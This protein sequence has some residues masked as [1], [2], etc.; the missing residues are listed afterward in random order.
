MV[1]EKQRSSR[2]MA[3][4]YSEKG[5]SQRGI[6]WHR[7]SSSNNSNS[8]SKNKEKKT[9]EKLLENANTAL[10]VFDHDVI[11][12]VAA[13]HK[14]RKKATITSYFTVMLLLY[15]MIESSTP[16][17][18]PLLFSWFCSMNGSWVNGLRKEKKNIYIYLCVPIQEK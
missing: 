17:T 4:E 1:Y 15:Q 16:S 6:R 8:I 9:K 14:N 18:F 11:V 2:L 12:V 7:D 3:S 10:A 5:V 13:A